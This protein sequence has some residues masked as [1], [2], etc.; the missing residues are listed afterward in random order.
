MFIYSPKFLLCV[1]L[2]SYFKKKFFWCSK[3]ELN[4]KVTVV[5]VNVLSKI[6]TF[7]PEVQ[8]SELAAESGTPM[9]AQLRAPSKTDRPVCPLPRLWECDSAGLGLE[10]L[11]GP[12][13][14]HLDTEGTKTQNSVSSLQDT[15]SEKKKRTE[16][17]PLFS[18]SCG[19]T[20]PL[21][22][23]F[24]GLSVSMAGMVSE[25]SPRPYTARPELHQE[26]TLLPLV[27]K[28]FALREPTASVL[29]FTYFP[30]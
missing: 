4:V 16:N 30:C 22:L 5:K 13:K 29:L 9:L 28:A 19:D 12:C 3:D 1:V 26:N 2:K 6:R 20:I 21:G 23:Y 24:S 15:S 8:N 18:K 25:A 17:T 11:T 14:T 7:S 10:A 27:S